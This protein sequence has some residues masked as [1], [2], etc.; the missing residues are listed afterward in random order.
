MTMSS[1]RKTILLPALML[2]LVLGSTTP[3]LGQNQ[4]IW[5]YLRPSPVQGPF[6]TFSVSLINLTEHRLLITDNSISL[7]CEKM[8]MIH[9]CGSYQSNPFEGHGTLNLDPYRTAIWKSHEGNHPT[10]EDGDNG[11]GWNGTLTVQPEGMDEWAVTLNA[12]AEDAYQPDCVFCDSNTGKGTWVYLQTDFSANPGWSQAWNAFSPYGIWVTPNFLN[13]YPMRNVMTLSG[14]EVAVS[15]YTATTDNNH[16]T[17][18]FRQNF[19]PDAASDTLD[20]SQSALPW[21][22]RPSFGSGVYLNNYNVTR[23][24]QTFTA[25]QPGILDRVSVY[26][27]DSYIA[28]EPITVSIQTA[29]NGLPSGIEIG[30]ATIPASAIP[31]GPYYAPNPKWVSTRISP[32]GTASL[33]MTPGTQYA[34]VLSAGATRNQ[35]TWYG[36]GDVYPGGSMVDQYSSGWG[37]VSNG[38]AMFQTYIIPPTA[39]GDDYVGW[40]LSF[41]DNAG[42]SV[43]LP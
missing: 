29:I 19:Y 15:L 17:L 28:T 23:M 31:F 18:V 40:P 43:P 25:G 41:V 5:V 16:V 1:L 35:I 6:L 14:K 30:H 38:D 12:R 27:D 10:G 2:A 9:S 13:N 22:Y 42:S 36:S 7:T 11:W 37:I 34:I 21:I 24:A 26:I 8:N 39:P 33:A 32:T 3:A 20:Q 4:G